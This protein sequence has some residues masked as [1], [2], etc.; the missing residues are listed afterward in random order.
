MS[1]SNTL[2]LTEFKPTPIIQKL[3]KSKSSENLDMISETQP[4]PEPTIKKTN[5]RRKNKYANDEERKEARRQQQRAYR[6]RKKHE[7]ELLHKMVE[8]IVEEED[9]NDIDI[10]EWKKDNN[11]D[12]HAEITSIDQEPKDETQ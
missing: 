2:D 8:A 5:R 3:S 10:E 4:E 1:E 12:N 7:L 9:I 6:L 11:N